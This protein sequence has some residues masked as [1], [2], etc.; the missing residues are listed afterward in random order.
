MHA[1]YLAS[2]NH[3]NNTDQQW[4]R[5]CSLRLSH[6]EVLVQGGMVSIALLDMEPPEQRGLHIFAPSAFLVLE[7]NDVKWRYIQPCTE[8]HQQ[9]IWIHD[10]LD[11]NLQLGIEL[12]EP[13]EVC[14][15]LDPI[16]PAH[17]RDS[18]CRLQR[19]ATLRHAASNDR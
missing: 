15:S 14:M 19:R 17:L 1:F 11:V 3:T 16:K 9:L 8:A 12:H 13:I 6:R 2:S 18:K 7:H 5:G 10:G 4:W